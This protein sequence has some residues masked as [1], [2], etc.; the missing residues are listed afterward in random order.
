ML[1]MYQTKNTNWKVSI[2]NVIR[3]LYQ[4][5][6]KRNIIMF[7]E[8]EKCCRFYEI[9]SFHFSSYLLNLLSAFRRKTPKKYYIFPYGLLFVK[10][11]LSSHFFFTWP[12]HFCYV[13]QRNNQIIYIY[14]CLPSKRL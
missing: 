5:R 8:C 14:M 2:F 3:T 9:K 6:I 11:W 13:N 10:T 7:K 12:K 4:L 1:K